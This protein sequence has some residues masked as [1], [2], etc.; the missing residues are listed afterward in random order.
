MPTKTAFQ[1][2]EEERERK[3]MQK[4]EEEEL[5]AKKAKQENPNSVFNVLKRGFLPTAERIDAQM[6]ADREVK[7]RQK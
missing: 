4:K 1:A 3:R 2:A 7:R 6:A 5:E